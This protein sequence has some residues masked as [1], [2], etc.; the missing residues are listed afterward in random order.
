M[1][2]ELYLPKVWIDDVARRG[3]AHV[4][5]EDVFATKPQLAQKMIERA[6]A[7]QVPFAWITGDEVYG[8]NCSL[9]VWLEQ[10]E[11]HFVLAVACNQYVW[12]DMGGRSW[13]RGSQ[14]RCRRRT[15]RACR[16]VTAPKVRACMSGPEYRCYRGTCRGNA[17]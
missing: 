12:P 5:E 9:R 11:R 1:D 13:W 15:G 3:A 6:M 17:G 2:R 8:D 10:Q 4:P 16:L 14:R 7:A